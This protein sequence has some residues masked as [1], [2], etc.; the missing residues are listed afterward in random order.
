MFSPPPVPPMSAV[1]APLLFD[2]REAERQAALDRYALLDTAPD[3]AC[4]DIV[5]VA[6]MV[7]DGPAAAIDSAI[8]IKSASVAAS[9][10]RTCGRPPSNAAMSLVFTGVTG[11]RPNAVHSTRSP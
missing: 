4:D 1:P 10:T 9:T 6:A 11:S 5:R 3:P 2:A 7:C 8:P